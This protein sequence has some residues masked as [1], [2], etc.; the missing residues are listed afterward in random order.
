M[1]KGRI[2]QRIEQFENEC[3]KEIKINDSIKSELKN[4]TELIKTFE[5]KF[6]QWNKE[7]TELKAELNDNYWN[8]M[9]K[10]CEEF[11]RKLT[12]KQD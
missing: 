10:E 5:A 9:L 4:Y 1:R 7:L 6:K 8:S 11:N 3:Q 2:I 12:K